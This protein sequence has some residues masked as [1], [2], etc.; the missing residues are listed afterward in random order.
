MLI[1]SDTDL[2][3][4]IQYGLAGLINRA[5]LNTGFLNDLV[6]VSDKE[7]GWQYLRLSD[8]KIVTTWAMN[9]SEQNAH[10]LRSIQWQGMPF[11]VQKLYVVAKAVGADIWI[12][13]RGGLASLEAMSRE[14]IMGRKGWQIS[15]KRRNTSWISG[16]D[17]CKV[18]ESK[19]I[20]FN[21]PKDDI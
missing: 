6:S 19:G 11:W 13:I 2:Y 4:G 15:D 17:F 7:N 14:E 1:S 20:A 3:I 12:G 5:W 10:G 18:L 16:E 8:F 21:S 9:P